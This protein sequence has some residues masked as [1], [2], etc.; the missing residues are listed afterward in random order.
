MHVRLLALLYSCITSIKVMVIILLERYSKEF[1]TYNYYIV[2][3]CK[4]ES[5][6]EMTITKDDFTPHPEI[7]VSLCGQQSQFSLYQTS[8]FYEKDILPY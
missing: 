1:C 8:H 6:T 5:K 2:H 7:K 4:I 3:S